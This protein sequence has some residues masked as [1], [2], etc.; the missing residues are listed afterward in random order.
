MVV[1]IR[2]DKMREILVC[3]LWRRPEF[4]KVWIDL[5]KKVDNPEGI[6]FIFCLDYSYDPLNEQ[7]LDKYFPFPYGVIKTPDQR[8]KMGKQSFNVLNGLM[9]AMNHSQ[10]LIYYLEEDVFPGK[11]FFNWHRRIHERESDI[12]CSIATRNNNTKY[13]TIDNP[14]YYYISRKPDYQALGTCFKPEVLR[15]Y[16][17]PHFMVDYFKDPVGYCIRNFPDSF[18]GKFYVEQ[19]GLI[20]RIIEQ[21]KKPIAFPHYPRAYHAGFYGYNRRNQFHMPSFEAKVKHIME[22]AFDNEKMRRVSLNEYYYQDSMPIDLEVMS[23]KCIKYDV[24]P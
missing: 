10:G 15:E 4:L 7:I 9:S 14:D 8:L 24:N 6:Y 19:D 16:I 11:D 5:I 22:H 13:Q 17:L 2:E 3:P 20:R 21:C 12:F 18:I 1:F 23:D